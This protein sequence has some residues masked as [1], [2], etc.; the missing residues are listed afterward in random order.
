MSLIRNTLLAASGF[1]ALIFIIQTL[2]QPPVIWEALGGIAILGTLTTLSFK[3]DTHEL[4]NGEIILIWS[5][6]LL[7]SLYALLR[8]GGVI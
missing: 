5:C 3:S 6:I 8:A 2:E 1:Y 4:H 7:F